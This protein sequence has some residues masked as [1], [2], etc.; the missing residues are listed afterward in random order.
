MAY[1]N[2][3]GLPWRPYEDRPPFKHMMPQELPTWRR[4]IAAQPDRFTEVVYDVHVGDGA[5]ITFTSDPVVVAWA[6]H[7]TQLRVDVLGRSGSR[8]TIIEVRRLPGLSSVGQ[9]LCYATL[10]RRDFAYSGELRRLLVCE[11]ITDDIL[12]LAR[13]ARIEVV[14]VPAEDPS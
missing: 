8:L 7:L 3:R 1:R 4:F 13:R 2:V 9:I 5:T 6:K 10:L 12:Y 11:Y 14:V